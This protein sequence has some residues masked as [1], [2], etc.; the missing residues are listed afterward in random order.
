MPDFMPRKKYLKFLI[1]FEKGIAFLLMLWYYYKA[2]C[3]IM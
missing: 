1:F 3:A 2:C